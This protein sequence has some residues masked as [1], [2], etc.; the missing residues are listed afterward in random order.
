VICV[1]RNQLEF[2]ADIIDPE[3]TFFVPL[4]VDTE[5]FTPPD[6]FATRDPDLCLFVGANYRDYPTL[7]GVIDLV[8]YCRPQTQFVA[9]MSPQSIELIG[10]HPNLTVLSGIPEPK[11]RELYRSAA[12]MVLPMKDA[13]ANNTVLESMACG[14][15]MVV[16][17]VG[18]TRD[19]VSDECAAF[20]P[21]YH[22]QKMAEVVLDLLAEPGE[23]RRMSRQAREQALKFSWPKVVEQ[24]DSVYRAVN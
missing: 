5:Y 2:F 24:L 21:A 4:G 17:D 16:T 14:L 1:G 23:K 22:S 6:S 13:T 12:L 7:R 10:Q 20:V 8:S 3:R 9:V 18:A 15:P 19:Y 11:L